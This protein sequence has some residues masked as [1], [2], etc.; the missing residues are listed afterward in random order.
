MLFFF[1]L[2]KHSVFSLVK[3]T[4]THM[5][6]LTE[7]EEEL[8]VKMGGKGGKKRHKEMRGNMFLSLKKAMKLFPFHQDVKQQATKLD[9]LSYKSRKF[10][11]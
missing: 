2:I 4:L 6:H 5:P 11:P 3:H 1:F 8:E 7:E 10:T 9:P